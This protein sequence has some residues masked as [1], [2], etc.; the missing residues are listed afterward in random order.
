MD[1]EIVR[2]IGLYNES[3]NLT[4]YDNFKEK[5]YII[6]EIDEYYKAHKE[7]DSFEMVDALCDI[8]VFSIGSLY[9]KIKLPKVTTVERITKAID[10]SELLITTNLDITH[11]ISQIDDTPLVIAIATALIEDMGYD[12]NACMR[13]VIHHIESRKGEINKVTGKFEKYTD[14]EHIAQWVNPQYYM[15]KHGDTESSS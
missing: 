1:I 14:A 3:R 4:E 7:K 12:A 13:E 6:E 8:I 2:D 9:K 5:G 15:C 10:S 11:L